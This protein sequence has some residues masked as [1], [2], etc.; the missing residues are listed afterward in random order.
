MRP[1]NLNRFHSQRSL[2]Y[3]QRTPPFY[4]IFIEYREGSGFAY[5]YELN[6]SKDTALQIAALNDAIVPSIRFD[7]KRIH[8]QRAR[9]RVYV[10]EERVPH[11]SRY[12]HDI[13][14][15]GYDGDFGGV[16]VTVE[17][18][19]EARPRVKALVEGRFIAFL[20]ASFKDENNELLEWFIEMIESV[21][22]E[23]N[24]LKVK[25]QVRPTEEKIRENITICNCFIQIITSDISI[26]GREAGWLGN[27][28]AW[29]KDSTPNGNI[30]IFVEKGLKATGLAGTVAD[31]VYFDPENLANDSPKIVQYLLDLRGRVSS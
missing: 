29:A 26:E 8:P 7:S 21:G 5:A 3:M 18:S 30:A 16:D 1:K 10:T 2:I 11:R 9:Y 28:I 24:W 19:L 13:Y 23:V 12:Y 4:Q 6:Q 25:Y 27:E 22:I 15:G 20:S 31:T 17:I 14:P